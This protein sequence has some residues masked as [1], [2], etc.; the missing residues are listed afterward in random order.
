[1]NAAD[2]RSAIEYTYP[3]SNFQLHSDGASG[4]IINKWLCEEEP[5]APTASG[6]ET[7]VAD[8]MT[9]QDYYVNAFD[10]VQFQSELF[11]IVPSGLSTIDLRLEFGAL[12]T[13]AYNKDFTGMTNYLN[14]LLSNSIATQDDVDAVSGIVTSQG[15]T[16]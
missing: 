1:M 7:I 11:D 4:V 16:L 6:M 13:Y 10:I 12:N 15:V 2:A 14:L 9:T 3:S 5:V 8:W